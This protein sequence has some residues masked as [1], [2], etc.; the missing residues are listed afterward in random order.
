MA[1]AVA[2]TDRK[3]ILIWNTILNVDL[4]ELNDRNMDGV[5]RGKKLRMTKR[6]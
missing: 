4:I 1:W 5:Q 6:F 3:K 2:I